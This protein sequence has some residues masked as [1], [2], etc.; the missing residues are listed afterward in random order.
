VRLGWK[1]PL[2]LEDIPDPGLAVQVAPNA[3]RFQHILEEESPAPFFLPLCF[4]ILTDI[5]K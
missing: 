4:F 2:R 5:A 1:R 3:A